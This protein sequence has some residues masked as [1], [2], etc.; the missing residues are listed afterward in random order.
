MIISPVSPIICCSSSSESLDEQNDYTYSLEEIKNH[1]G[2]GIDAS[3]LSV[4][5]AYVKGLD[6]SSSYIKK[7]QLVWQPFF[8][9]FL[10]RLSFSK[11]N[12]R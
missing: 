3:N 12:R 6:Y 10:C 5:D 4:R 2:A 11:F 8:G 7:Q 9:H 1:L